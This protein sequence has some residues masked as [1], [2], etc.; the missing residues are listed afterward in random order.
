MTSRTHEVSRN[1]PRHKASDSSNDAAAELSDRKLIEQIAAGDHCAMRMLYARHYKNLLRVATSFVRNHAGAED[2]VG[3]VFLEVWRNAGSFQNRSEVSTW[4]CAIARN[5]AI[6]A[7]R[8]STEPLDEEAL[9]LVE[10][11]SCDPETE[12]YNRHT[13]SAIR[14]CVGALSPAHRSV[15]ELFYFGDNTTADVAGMI[16]ITRGTVKTRLFYAR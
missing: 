11:E 2:I 3:D 16:G 4:L 9:S 8:R 15:V 5:K 13:S 7:W 12:V 6:A 1:S 14:K 10:D